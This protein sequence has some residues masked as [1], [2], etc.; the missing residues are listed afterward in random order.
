[1]ERDLALSLV[2]IAAL[3]G[4][5]VYLQLRQVSSDPPLLYWFAGFLVFAALGDLD[6]MPYAVAVAAIF[7]ATGFAIAKLR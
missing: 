7:A 2:A 1:M 3:Y 6:F 5:L 4:F